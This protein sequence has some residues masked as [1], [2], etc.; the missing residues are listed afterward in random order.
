MSSKLVTGNSAPPK[1]KGFTD[2]VSVRL[3]LVSWVVEG[4]NC[5][6]P[7]LSV[8]LEVSRLSRVAQG[9]CCH[10]WIMETGHRPGS[11]RLYIAASPF[12]LCPWP[13]YT[14]TH[15]GSHTHTACVNLSLC[16]P[17]VFV[18]KL[19]RTLFA[20]IVQFERNSLKIIW[21]DWFICWCHWFCKAGNQSMKVSVDD[22]ISWLYGAGHL[23][24]N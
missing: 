4:S 13:T 19:D 3:R 5:A 2:P 18:D 23:T 8:Y 15:A 16:M 24:L 14:Y 1:Q 17:T 22:V 6:P 11:D 10:Y 9:P 7:S 12:S 20:H 21:L